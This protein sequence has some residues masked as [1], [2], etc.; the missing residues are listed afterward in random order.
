M[1][2]GPSP[3]QAQVENAACVLLVCV[4][5]AE[6]EQ[7]S[8]LSRCSHHVFPELSVPGLDV[9]R[10]PKCSGHTFLLWQLT[11]LSTQIP[12]VAQAAEGVMWLLA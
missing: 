9:C 12:I 3:R 8:V 11:C 10:D 1:H 6:E 4:F 5:L 7:G 2:P